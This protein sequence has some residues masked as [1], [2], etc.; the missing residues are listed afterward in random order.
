MIICPTCGK[1][2][3]SLGYARHRAMHYEKAQKEKEAAK[4][5]KKK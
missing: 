1:P 3:K 5:S 2:F 4:E